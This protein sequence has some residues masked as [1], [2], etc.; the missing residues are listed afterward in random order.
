LRR[1]GTV[2]PRVQIPGPRPKSEY[3]DG[4]LAG[5]HGGAVSQPYHKLQ[6]VYI[7]GRRTGRVAQRRVMM[8]TVT[9]ALV[10]RRC[11]LGQARLGSG[12]GQSQLRRPARLHLDERPA[13]QT[14]VRQKQ[15]QGA[16]GKQVHDAA[17]T[18]CTVTG[19]R[20]DVTGGHTEEEADDDCQ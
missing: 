8:G 13:D 4:F 7:E 16:D 6:P 5:A 1:F 20:A 17:G 18:R 12:G 14:E 3:D 10:Q 15:G 19:A 2:R 11:D 9:K